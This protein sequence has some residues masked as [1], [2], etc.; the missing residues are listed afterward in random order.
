MGATV[1]ASIGVGFAVG[2]AED[3]H[4][5]V[6]TVA[7]PLYVAPGGSATELTLVN[8]NAFIEPDAIFNECV[9]QLNVTEV[10]DAVL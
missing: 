7:E 10:N 1:G 4:T 6:L 2:E 9:E 3:G 5:N 8:L